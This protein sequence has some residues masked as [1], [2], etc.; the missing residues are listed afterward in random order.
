MA[1]FRKDIIKLLIP[2]FH[3]DKRYILMLGDM[4]FGAINELK[5]KF[6]ERVINFGIIEQGAAGIA[7]GMSLAGLIP[8]YYTIVN[9]I[10]FR[11]IE[12]V[13]NDV[14][15]QG[16]NVKFIGTGAKNYF[17]KLGPS[18]TCEDQDVE[19]MKLIKMDVFDPYTTDKSFSDL[20]NDWIT[21]PN[22]GYIRV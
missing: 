16:L 4:G 6:P 19:I 21:S 3:R 22:A 18:H 13:R 17:H 5:A 1:D 11:A 2:H 9:F 14:L 8:I 20:I 12:Q 15:L 10:A 7:A